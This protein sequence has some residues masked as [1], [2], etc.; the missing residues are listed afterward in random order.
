[1]INIRIINETDNEELWYAQGEF[2]ANR[3]EAKSF[4]TVDQAIDTAE[5]IGAG[6]CFIGADVSQEEME[7]NPT[8]FNFEEI[9]V[10]DG[11]EVKGSVEVYEEETEGN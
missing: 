8:A 4:E 1:M 9:Q 5:A 10:L 6:I 2:V 7:A 3:A 11:N